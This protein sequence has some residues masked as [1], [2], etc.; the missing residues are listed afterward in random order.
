MCCYIALIHKDVDSDYGVSFPDFPGC[1]TAGPT[2]H[3]AR[4]LAAEALAFHIEGLLAD[5][6]AIPEPSTFGAVMT[7]PKNRDAVAILVEWP[8]PVQGAIQAGAGAL[9][10]D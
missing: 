10:P 7:D 5:G 9:L 4:D 6:Q 8:Q 1:I 2:L 3:E